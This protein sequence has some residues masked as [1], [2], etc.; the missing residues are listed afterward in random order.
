MADYTGQQWGS[1]RLLRLLG[2]GGFADVYLGE[3]VHL[4]TQAAIKILTTQM[5]EQDI[6]H[7][8]DEARIIHQLEHP[9][10]VRILDFGIENRIPF[11]AMS[12][13]PGGSVRTQHPR[14]AVLPLQTV[15]R[16]IKQIAEALQY[17]HDQKLIHRD[18]KPENMLL[19]KNGKLL[20]SDFGIAA[21][22]H[23]TRSLNTQDAS[24]TIYYMAPEQIQG[25]PR[26]ASDQYALGITVYEWL[27]GEQPFKGSYTEILAKHL[28]SPPSPLRDKRSDLLP[29]VEEVV[30][31]S[32][33][34]EPTQR[35]NNVL[36]F[37]Q[38]LEDASRIKNASAPSLRSTESSVSIFISFQ[39][40]STK[41]VS[42]YWIN[43]QG[44]EV[45][46]CHLSPKHSY[47][48]QTYVTHPW[49]IKDSN[50]QVLKEFIANQNIREIF[51]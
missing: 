6:A 49:R 42:I 32:L 2:T 43:Y 3:H 25:K 48:Q 16:Y 44:D 22:A 26:P 33:S 5:A 34:K 46:Y 45:F 11:I 19:G 41:I 24:G 51:I 28:T 23:S 29:K 18:V 36:L 14:G 9:H 10:V 8:R 21:V 40:T 50:G 15:V 35:F 30:F 38:A 7:F 13:A 39:N 47:T 4:G 31:K 1:Y 12:Y 37:A 27:S 17:V 20:L